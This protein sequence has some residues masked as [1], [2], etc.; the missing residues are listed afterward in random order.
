MIVNRNPA[1]LV[2]GTITLLA[3]IRFLWWLFRTLDK[4]GYKEPT[5][6]DTK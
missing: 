3:G 2:Y 4:A 6:E 1:E 5:K